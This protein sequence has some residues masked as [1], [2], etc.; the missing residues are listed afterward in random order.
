MRTQ[1][2][3][4][5]GQPYGQWHW[6]NLRCHPYIRP[7]VLCCDTPFLLLKIKIDFVAFSFLSFFFFIIINHN[8]MYN[9]IE[10]ISGIP[11]GSQWNRLSGIPVRFHFPPGSQLFYWDICKRLGFLKNPTAVKIVLI[12]DF[13]V[14]LN[15]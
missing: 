6:C 5:Y 15:R 2:V 3:N 11:P 8:F 9:P 14:E 1:L 4:S 13:N 7:S 10:N 12:Y